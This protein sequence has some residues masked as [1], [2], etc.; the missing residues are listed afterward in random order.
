LRLYSK[1]IFKSIYNRYK[2]GDE[3]RGIDYR[4]VTKRRGR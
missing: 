3:T 1:S 4:N 2:N